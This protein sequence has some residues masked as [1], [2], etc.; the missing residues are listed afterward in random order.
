[1]NLAL[2]GRDLGSAA[3]L[4]ALVSMPVF[5]AGG[6]G[7]VLSGHFSDRV[8]RITAA[9]GIGL[10]SIAMCLTV[11]WLLALPFALLALVVALHYVLALADSPVLS[12][13]LTEIVAPQ[14][15]GSALGVYA[16]IGWLAGAISPAVFGA[17]LDMTGGAWGVAFSA[18]G[19]GA[20]LGPC[21]LL[22]LRRDRAHTRLAPAGAELPAAR[23]GPS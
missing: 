20:L 16:A 3:G 5:G 23:P 19:L 15:V 18:L 12:T 17:V 11:G 22:T 8:G 9:L 14:R 13:A 2:D 4:A 1:A 7:V 10:A 6:L 21:V